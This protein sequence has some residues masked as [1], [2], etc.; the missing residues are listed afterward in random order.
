MRQIRGK[1]IIFNEVEIKPKTSV[2]G[3]VTNDG[4]PLGQI[5]WFAQ[6]RK[7]SFFPNADTVFEK[8][9]LMEIVNFIEKLMMDRA[10]GKL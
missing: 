8:T 9:C 3:I 5:K 10:R 7:Y 4:I 6:W 2:W 1:W